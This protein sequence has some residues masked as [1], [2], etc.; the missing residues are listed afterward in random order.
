MATGLKKLGP[1]GNEII[2]S[3]LTCVSLLVH[4]FCSFI[5]FKMYIDILCA[6]LRN[7]DRQDRH[8]SYPHINLKNTRAV[9]VAS[10]QVQA[11]C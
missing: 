2:M 4:V 5:H 7:N 3:M 8:R 11:L 10:L 9:F 6:V 1:L